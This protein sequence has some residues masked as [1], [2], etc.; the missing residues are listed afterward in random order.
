[1]SRFSVLSLTDEA[2]VRVKEIMRINHARGILVGVK[3]GGCAGMEYTVDLVVEEL[4]G[5]DIV[6]KD[7]ARVFIAREAVL[8]LLGTLMDFEITTL[9][10][11]F[12]F[13]N[14]N[15]TSACGCGQSVD[16]IPASLDMLKK[17]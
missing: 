17:K 8:F 14:P 12:V 9:R 13:K 5:L 7:D 15:Q 11:G 6:E 10:T 1:M 3:K 4:S 2:V 16:I